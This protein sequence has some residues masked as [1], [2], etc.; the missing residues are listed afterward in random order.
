MKIL[1]FA[2]SP[3]HSLK[4]KGIYADMIS[5]FNNQG[6]YVDYFFPSKKIF[7]YTED[8][9]SYKSIKVKANPQ[10]QSNFI[11]KFL[12]Y[13]E[14]EKTMKKSI[15]Q[16][17]K[18]YDM[19]ILV[20]PS[21]FQ[22]KVIDTFKKMNPNATVILLLKDIF[23]DNA[24]D[25]GILKNKFP[26]NLAIKYFKSIEKN[27]YKK[28][29]HIGCMTQLNM[30]YVSRT[31]P[32]IKNKLFLSPNSI[33]PYKIKKSQTRKT[34]GLPEN[35][36]LL[37]FVGN[38]GLPQDPFFIQEFVNKLPINMYMIIIGTGSKFIFE[39][40]SNLLVINR[41]MNQ[42]EIDQYL[43][44]SDYGLVFLSNKF[45]VPNFPSKILSYLNANLPIISFSNFYND[46]NPYYFEKNYEFKTFYWNY[47]NIF[48]IEKINNELSSIIL[49]KNIDINV[50]KFHVIKQISAL[51]ERVTYQ[52]KTNLLPSIK[53]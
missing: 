53:L 26:F 3:I 41:I 17:K 43:I 24:I 8:K 19:L 35:K 42:D 52:F 22:L 7:F 45:N 29:D 15:K 39:T 33:N 10:K 32:Y 12:L 21:I 16:S 51:K 47:S 2:L 40:K 5:E 4:E 50:N 49:T 36:I 38:I 23:P 18:Y 28:V 30:A 6:D 25:L 13:L 34:L 46:L 37:I 48:E 44:N 14:V 1:F 11:K 20:T 9:V 27:L 31:H